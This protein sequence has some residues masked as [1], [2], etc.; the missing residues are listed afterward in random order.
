[1]YKIISLLIV[2][3]LLSGA[4][5][6]LYPTLSDQYN[7]IMSA[8]RI[9]AYDLAA[10]SMAP[11]KNQAMLREAEHYNET[12]R[13]TEL[14]DAF[15]EAANDTSAEYRALLNMSEDG[16]MGYVEV[17]KIGVRLPI[18]H[19][20]D[21]YGLQ[22]GTGHMEGTALP[23]G[24]PSTH[25][26]IAGH[27]ALPSAR[28]FTDLDQMERGDLI[29]LCVLG[30]TLVYQV[31][32]I[33]VVLPHELDYMAVEEG[34]D[35]LTLVTCTPYGLNTHRLLVRGRRVHLEDVADQL[36]ARDGVERLPAWKGIPICTAPMAVV[37]ALIAVL[38]PRKK[39]RV[40]KPE[41]TK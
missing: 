12:L 1:M 29:F 26:G 24:G 38:W 25:C 27:R 19:S 2:V 41:K 37:G 4:G 17:P 39:Y 40:N 18:Y 5:L 28:L 8:R 13:H 31:D 7:Q 32:L 15:T 30:E 33:N 3:I 11:E 6:V 9:L 23:V 10:R 16:I 36:A 14:H 21:D 34:E 22:R 20:T 35:L